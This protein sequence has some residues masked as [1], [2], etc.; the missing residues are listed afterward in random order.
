MLAK[1]GSCPVSQR[2]SLCSGPGN[3][4]GIPPHMLSIALVCPGRQV[5]SRTLALS[6]AGVRTWSAATHEG[7]LD[8]AGVLPLWHSP[9]HSIWWFLFTLVF[10]SLQ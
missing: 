9:Q 2:S 10:Q 7:R 5:T 1:L 3:T 8:V 6:T 4:H